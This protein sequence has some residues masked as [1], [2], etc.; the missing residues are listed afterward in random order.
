M[1]VGWNFDVGAGYRFNSWFRTD[2]TVGMDQP[3]SLSIAG[4]G[5]V[6]CPYN[7]SG[8]TDQVT[9]YQVGYLWSAQAG[10]CSGRGKFSLYQSDILLNSYVD[11]GT[12]HNITPY[13]GAGVGVAQIRTTGSFNY[14]KT[15][16]GTAYGADLSPTGTYP[17]IWTD[18]G[19]NALSPQ[20]NVPGTANPVAFAKQ[21]WAQSYKD[22]RYN[23]A[24]ALMG[25]VAYNVTD[26]TSIDVGYRYVNRG[27]YRT[28]SAQ[29]GLPGPEKTWSTQAVR[30]GFRYMID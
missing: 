25:G 15:S 29:T 3:Q 27:N 22:T 19:G 28:I 13:V 12:W 30:V 23:F 24:W 1:R 8:L 18:I 14:Y 5:N 6:I 10:T 16:D 7:L 21:N 17:L 2:L 26:H 20:P 4:T 11:L 9:G